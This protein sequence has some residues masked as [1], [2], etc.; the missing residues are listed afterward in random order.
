M[1]LINKMLQDLEQRNASATQNQALA[2]EVRAVPASSAPRVGMK[3]GLVLL[4]LLAAGGIWLVMKPKPPES[5]VAVATPAPM[6]VLAPAPAPAPAPTPTPVPA[7]VPVSPVKAIPPAAPAPVVAQRVAEKTP[8]QA[9]SAVSDVTASKPGTVTKTPVTVA[10]EESSP[11][12]QKAQARAG[13]AGDRRSQKIVSSQQQSDNLYKQ[14]IGELQQ[15]RGNDA[16]RTLQRALEANQNNVKARQT[17]VGMLVE[18]NRLEEASALLREGLK[19]SPE[20]ADFTM[21]LAR[22]QLETGDTKGAMNTLE[23]GLQSA[24]D[25]PQYHAFYAALIQGAGR[26]EE[27]VRHYLVALRSDPAMPTWLVGIGISLQALSKDVDAVEAF[28]RARDTEK[29][30][31]QL[32]QFVDQRLSQLKP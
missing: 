21:T 10:A 1:S 30:T 11:V 8:P 6:P 29:L 28:R 4:T 9:T 7:P 2:G 25:D 19:L 31:P 20:Q 3:V 16:R 15:G 17:L 24:A 32:I 12:R 26:H 5:V 27:S 14:A 22:L 13:T 18:G 23:Q